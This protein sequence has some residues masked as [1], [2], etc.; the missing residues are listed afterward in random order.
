MKVKHKQ[1]KK[2]SSFKKIQKGMMGSNYVIGIVALLVV[3]GLAVVG[4]GIPSSI[5]P[6]SGQIV[7]VVTPTPGQN[8]SNLQLKWFGYVTLAPTP[9]LAPPAASSLCKSGGA[10]DEPEILVGYFPPIGQAVGATGQV[11]V[12]VTD[13]GAPIISQGEQINPTTGQITTPGNR[14]QK[15]P[16]GY[17]WEPALYISPQTAES[18]G[19]PHFPTAIKGDYNNNPNSPRSSGSFVSGMDPPPAGS[20][21]LQYKAEDIWDVSSLGLG[22][23]TYEAEFV[24]HD[25]DDNRGVGCVAIQ[26]Q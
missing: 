12:W 13:E 24:I 22:T 19:T 4:G 26:I 6:S 11:K 17:Y 18:G 21:L 14:A 25:G 20:Q 9:T 3:A 16:D 8:Y 2:K 7:S 23:G 1:K 10:N 15:A 5:S